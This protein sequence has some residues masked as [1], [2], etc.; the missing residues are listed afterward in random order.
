MPGSRCTRQ[1][2]G[3][4]NSLAPSTPGFSLSLTRCPDQCWPLLSDCLFV[5]SS[6]PLT[7]LDFPIKGFRKDCSHDCLHPNPR[8]TMYFRR[9]PHEGM[10]NLN[11]SDTD[12]HM[13]TLL[14]TGYQ[15]Q[16]ARGHS[17][18]VEG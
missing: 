10:F 18:Q 16:I 11:L 13:D 14:N 1:L 7:H 6:P 12:T 17:Q 9:N 8:L 2:V 4:A 15:T 3:W 5:Y